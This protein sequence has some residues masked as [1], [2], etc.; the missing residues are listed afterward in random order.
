MKK[1]PFKMN[2]PGKK[3]DKAVK[4]MMSVFGKKPKIKTFDLLKKSPTGPREGRTSMK[5]GPSLETRIINR[6]KKQQKQKLKPQA[7]RQP[8]TKNKSFE[9]NRNTR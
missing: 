2:G 3:A 8:K 6:Y 4:G 5:I 9:I 1:A 7:E